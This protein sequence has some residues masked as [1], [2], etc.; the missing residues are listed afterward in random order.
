M[1]LKQLVYRVFYRARSGCKHSWA[2]FK[3]VNRQ[4]KSGGSIQL[5]NCYLKS[6]IK[7]V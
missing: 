6:C 5:C 1:D 2:T 3:H 7:T 4:N